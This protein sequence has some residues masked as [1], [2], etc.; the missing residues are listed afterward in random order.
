M[1]D[2]LLMLH[3]IGLALGVGTSFAMLALGKSAATLDPPERL[4]F[5]KRIGGLSKN[6]S[7]GLL[8]LIATGLGML[9]ARGVGTTFATAG[10]AFHVKLTL[11]VVLA[12]CLGYSQVLQKRVRK[13]GGGP[14][15]AILPKLGAAMLLLGLAIV[16]A[17]VV[18]FH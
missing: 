5:F 3:F 10:V 2:L 17:A 14:A 18:A 16:A 7:F 1:Y 12:G 4:V 6:G 8:L 11:V 13:E 9:F 15:L